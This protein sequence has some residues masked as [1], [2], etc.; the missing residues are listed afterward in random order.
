MRLLVLDPRFGAAGDMITGALLS[1][2][3][4]RTAVLSAMRSV[5]GMPVVEPV[6]RSGVSALHVQTNTGPAHRTLEEVLARVRAASAPAPAVALAEQVFA[7]IAAAEAKVHGTIH[8]H[9]HEVGADD[10][11]ADV[12]GACTALVSLGVDAVHILPV[13]TGSGTLTCAHG[14]MPVP[15]PA[16]AEILA[17]SSLTVS[18]GGFSGELCTPTGAALLAEFS[19]AFG[20]AEHTGRVL[21]QGFGAGTRDPA[22]HPNVLR[23]VLMESAA[24]FFGS[25][26]DVLETN[27]DDLSGELMSAAMSLLLTAGARDVCIVPAIMKKGRP[28]HLIRVICLPEDTDRLAKL[29]ARET[30]SLG[31]RCTPM[32]HR[33]VA[34]RSVSQ[35]TVVV[36]GE[37]YAIDVKTACMDAVPYSRKAEFDQLFR[38]A[39]AAGVSVRD[40]KRIVE[41]ASWTK[42]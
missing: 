15:A 31:I 41:E 2:G 39:A 20:S 34:E 4:D 14:V 6:V 27:V 7:R 10:A 1:A 40:L 3:A 35:E 36:N 25:A 33:F 30:G 37:S 23:A 24:P 28:G 32:V 9:F 8:V 38:A 19:A 29:L 26:V 11:I 5:A 16:T 22:D 21:S 17:A 13:S 12:L 42:E 18:F